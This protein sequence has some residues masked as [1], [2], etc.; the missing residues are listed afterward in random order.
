MYKKGLL[1]NENLEW[2]CENGTQFYLLCKLD[3][4]S[5][6]KFR[7]DFYIILHL[8]IY[9]FACFLRKSIH[10]FPFPAELWHIEGKE[11]LSYCTQSSTQPTSSV[12]PTASVH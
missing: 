2:I 4:D 1:C 12:Q 9:C 3:V 5:I 7:T 8:W 6:Q 10:L 11:Y